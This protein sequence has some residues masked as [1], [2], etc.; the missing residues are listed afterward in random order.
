MTDTA[1]VARKVA[2][3]IKAISKE[4]GEVVSTHTETLL[5]TNKALERERDA[6]R[7]DLREAVA[8]IERLN[9]R[10]V[11]VEAQNRFLETERFRGA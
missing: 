7:D 3:D 1:A 9:R 11:E 10:L 6:V 8:E 2:G 5:L 4:L